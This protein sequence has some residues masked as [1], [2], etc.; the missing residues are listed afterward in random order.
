MTDRV[1]V[2]ATLPTFG[3]DCLT[4]C[5]E[6]LLPQVDH[7]FMVRT[8]PDDVPYQDHPQVTLIDAAPYTKNISWWWNLGIDAAAQA[9]A[10]GG[11]KRWDMLV[12]NDDVIVPPDLV[13]K[14]SEG[15]RSSWDASPALAYPDQGGWG[16]HLATDQAD[17]SRV[18]GYC[19]LLRGELGITADER[20]K[21]WFGDNAL[22]LDARARGGSVRVPGCA[23]QHLHPSGTTVASAELSAQTHLDAVEFRRLYPEAR[24]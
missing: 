11:H 10:D 13:A 2:Y 21:W 8:V 18:A 20:L 23:V 16:W 9:A 22:D 6:A 4:P 17:P 19:F 3:R 12:V 15:V 14:L 24:F 1:P 5:L 7:L